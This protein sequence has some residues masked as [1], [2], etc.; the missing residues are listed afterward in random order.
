M[1]R[2][3]V[4][5]LLVG[6]ERG[7]PI[8][9]KPTFK[10]NTSMRYSTALS[11]LLNAARIALSTSGLEKPMFINSLIAPSLAAPTLKALG[12][13]KAAGPAGMAT[14]CGAGGGEV[15]ILA[16][17]V[18]GTGSG[19]GP[20]SGAG[21]VDGTVGG[22]IVGVGVDGLTGVLGAGAAC[23]EYI[24]TE[25]REGTFLTMHTTKSFS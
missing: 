25:M 20:G 5:L 19:T 4:E 14:G 11:G 1:F 2:V 16:A 8:I 9:R 24:R 10:R 22:D 6:D 15:A 7:C 12:S 21:A 3:I 17:G 13:L 18:T 23:R